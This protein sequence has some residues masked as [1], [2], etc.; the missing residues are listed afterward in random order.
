[1]SCPG[2]GAAMDVGMSRSDHAREYFCGQCSSLVAAAP[3]FRRLLGDQRFAAIWN[4]PT[5]SGAGPTCGFCRAPM[6]PRVLDAGNAA[7][8]HTCQVLWFDREALESLPAAESA[9]AFSAASPTK[10]Q[11]CGAPISATVDGCCRYCGT[12]VGE[13][14]AAT[15][16]A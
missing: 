5:G 11:Y 15:S 10:C 4:A 3:V 14:E 12:V 6:Q 7:V 8:C 16:P 2:C 9:S 1:V 13:A